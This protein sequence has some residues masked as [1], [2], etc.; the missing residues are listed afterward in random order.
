MLAY[1]L[2]PSAAVA[3]APRYALLAQVAKSIASLARFG[4]GRI[5]V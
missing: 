3:K 2:V 4:N 1:M 5:Y